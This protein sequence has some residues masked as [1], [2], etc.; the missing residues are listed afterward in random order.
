MKEEFIKAIHD[1]KK[2]QLTF[3]SKEDAAPLSR[4][5][6]PMDFGPSRRAKDKSDRFHLWDFESDQGRHVLSILPGQVK[7]IEVLSEDFDPATFI[8]WS[9]TTSPWFVPRDWGA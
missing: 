7:S 8:T 5:C 4:K 2:V 3:F 6:A 9:T 1:K